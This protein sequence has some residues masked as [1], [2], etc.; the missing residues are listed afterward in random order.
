MAPERS[1]GD[2][3]GYREAQGGGVREWE[4]MQ[5]GVRGKRTEAGGYAGQWVGVLRGIRG[6]LPSAAREINTDTEKRRAEV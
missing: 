2:K 5:G 3:H 4:D 6:W 1:E